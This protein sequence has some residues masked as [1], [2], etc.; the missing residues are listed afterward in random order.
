MLSQATLDVNKLL[1]QAESAVV[2]RGRAYYKQFW[3]CKLDS[4]AAREAVVRVQGSQRYT[5][6][7]SLE[8]DGEIETLC[9]CPYADDEVS[10]ICKSRAQLRFHRR[11]V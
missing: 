1:A 9:D 8:D 7:I 11:A 5:V 4:L 6:Y 2:T 10:V 3:R